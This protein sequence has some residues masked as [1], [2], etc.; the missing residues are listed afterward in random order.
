MAVNFLKLP[1]TLSPLTISQ[2]QRINGKFGVKQ[3][4]FNYTGLSELMKM[5]TI[6]MTFFCLKLLIYFDL[7][8]SR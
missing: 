6:F 5:V 1:L 3:N 4:K 7:L 2:G 8:F